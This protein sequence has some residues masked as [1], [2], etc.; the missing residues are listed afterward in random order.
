M[1][2]SPDDITVPQAAA[3]TPEPAMSDRDKL[4]IALGGRVRPQR[5]TQPRNI[6]DAISNVT[7]NARTQEGVGAI[8]D[9]REFGARQGDLQNLMFNIGTQGDVGDAARQAFTRLA[10]SPGAA[11]RFF[12]GADQTQQLGDNQRNLDNLLRNRLRGGELGNAAEQAFQNFAQAPGL[13]NKFFGEDLTDVFTTRQQ[14]TGDRIQDR[15]DAALAQ[16]E[17]L[18]RLL[19]TGRNTRN[20]QT[21]AGNLKGKEITEKGA[22]DR[23]TITTEADRFKTQKQA[24]A[25][26]NKLELIRN[27]PERQKQQLVLENLEK[28]IAK[29]EAGGELDNFDRASLEAGGYKIPSPFEVTQE[30][31]KNELL[32][33]RTQIAATNLKTQLKDLGSPQAAAAKEFKQAEAQGLDR[34]ALESLAKTAVDN[35]F[36][37]EGAISE[38]FH[39]IGEA[40]EKQFFVDHGDALADNIVAS[41]G[42]RVT[43]NMA[44]IL[45]QQMAARA[46]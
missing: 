30:E 6:F 4:T 27:S 17:T 33:I 35:I 45:V 28:S 7:E 11:N 46:Q 21:I 3:A 24:E 2:T 16:R 8:G 38:K 39:F 26:A 31:M 29:L 23:T 37:K 36:A 42:G 25:E 40:P 43:P 9:R 41:G 1:E 14:A 20:E 44:A 13:A 5:Q 34:A 32:G 22:T 15:L 18:A 10:D 12:R 19:E